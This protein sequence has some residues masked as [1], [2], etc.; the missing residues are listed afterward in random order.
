MVHFLDWTPGKT[1]GGHI[2]ICGPLPQA[3]VKLRFMW[4]SV[5]LQ[6]VV[7]VV[8]VAHVVT[9]SHLGLV[10]LAMLW[11]SAV[12]M[13]WSVLPLETVLKSMACACCV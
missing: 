2:G 10:S 12:L 11:Q 4:L 5:V 8:S 13:S 7:I 1:P 9:K 3:M 6:Q